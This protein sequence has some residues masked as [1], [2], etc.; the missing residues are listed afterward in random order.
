MQR[1]KLL[2][3]VHYEGDKPYY[4]GG[5]FETEKN[6]LKHNV[7]GSPPRYQ[8]VQGDVPNVSGMTVPQL[9]AYAE[10]NQIDLGEATLKA[11]ILAIIQ[12]HATAPVLA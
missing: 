2:S 7:A 12:E 3:G 9:E 11:D 10:E 6:M 5:I 8:L 4:A 1:Y